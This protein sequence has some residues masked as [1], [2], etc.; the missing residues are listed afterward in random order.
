MLP[1]PPAVRALNLA[2]TAIRG[3]AIRLRLRQA[4]TANDPSFARAS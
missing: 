4:P 2:A 3:T 1:M